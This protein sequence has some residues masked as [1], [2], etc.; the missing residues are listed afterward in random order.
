MGAR[1]REEEGEE[2]RGG[3][4]GE[5]GEGAAERRGGVLEG[6]RDELTELQDALMRLPLN[7]G[8]SLSCCL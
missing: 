4:G 7:P 2:I 5:R 1:A 3:E 6:E 8:E